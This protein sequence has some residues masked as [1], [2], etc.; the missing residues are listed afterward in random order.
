MARS[1]GATAGILIGAAVVL[2]F[3]AGAWVYLD[4]RRGSTPDAVLAALQA[5]PMAARS[6]PGARLVT[7]EDRSAQR[8]DPLTGKPRTTQVLRAFAPIAGGDLRTLEQALIERARSAGWAV[9]TAADGSTRGSITLPFGTANLVIAV[10]RYTTPP[11]ITVMLA[12]AN[13]D[14]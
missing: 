10:N 9:S 7:A 14:L 12:P 6:L 2:A 8:S 11:T 5:D 1:I 4:G 13:P 3:A